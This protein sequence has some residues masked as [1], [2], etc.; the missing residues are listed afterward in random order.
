LEWTKISLENQ[1]QKCDV[2]QAKK[3]KMKMKMKKIIVTAWYSVLLAGPSLFVGLLATA[4]EAVACQS[5]NGPECSC[6]CTS[7]CTG[8]AVCGSIDLNGDGS[9]I[10]CAVSGTGCNDCGGGGGS[11]GMCGGST[12]M[13][14]S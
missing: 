9:C 14:E 10:D 8:N 2:T 11:G 12:P 13:C 1:A 7:T 3:G 6:G 4:P 5:E